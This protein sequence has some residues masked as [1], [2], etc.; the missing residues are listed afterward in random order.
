MGAAPHFP[1]PAPPCP[2]RSNGPFVLLYIRFLLPNPI[3]IRPWPNPAKPHPGG[4]H[5]CPPGP[6]GSALSPLSRLEK[7][8][9]S[10]LTRPLGMS[11]TSRFGGHR[12]RLGSRDKD[13]G[14]PQRFW[15]PPGPHGQQHWHEGHPECAGRAQSPIDIATSRAQP[16]PSLPP[17]LPE[18][19]ERP[20]SPQ[21]TLANNG[22]T[23]EHREGEPGGSRCRGPTDPRIPQ[24]CWR[25]RRP[26]GSGGCP[27]PSRPFSSTSTGAGPGAPLEPST[28]WTGTVPPP[29][30]RGTA[31]EMGLGAGNGL[32]KED[33]AGLGSGSGVGIVWEMVVGNSV[34]TAW[35]IG[36][37]SGNS[38]QG[39]E[40]RSWGWKWVLGCEMSAGRGW[41]A[42][43]KGE[44]GRGSRSGHCGVGAGTGAGV[45]GWGAQ[46]DWGIRVRGSGGLGWLRGLGWQGEGLRG[47]GYQ[48]EGLRGPPAPQMHVVH[49]DTERF[50][51]ASAAQRHPG[52]LA[53]LGVLL[54]VRTPPHA[55]HPPTRAAPAPH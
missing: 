40:K 6:A 42:E 55:P 44:N 28:C 49:F 48:G 43:K 11:P 51:D 45:A 14:V 19:Y 32:G 46:G 24:P 33:G 47:L 7:N 52:G 1:P 54:E 12:G 18:G 9:P 34:G 41:G 29:R 15:C 27:E 35:N 21:L 3:R 8:V 2:P 13:R 25:C 4:T 36:L 22:H 5:G 17:L 38:L 16:D 31:P 20:E 37:H 10:R 53:V 30:Y 26:C 23:G 50:A 39:M